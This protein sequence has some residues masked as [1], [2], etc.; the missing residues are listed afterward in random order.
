[1]KPLIATFV[2]FAVLGS[3]TAFDADLPKEKTREWTI[4]QGLVLLPM[5]DL[6]E[7]PAAKV[8]EFMLP[9]D[10]RGY[11]IK[12]DTSKV[13]SRLDRRLSLRER[14]VPWIVLLG[15]VADLL[16]ADVVIGEGT[17]KLV[18]RED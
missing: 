16:E 2:L 6:D 10:G 7:M 9:A 14:Q 4:K 13:K 18:P 8:I 15:K 12:I 3:A 17:Y 11:F 5:V 1:M